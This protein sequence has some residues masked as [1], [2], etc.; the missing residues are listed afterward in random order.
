MQTLAYIPDMTLKMST[1]FCD[2]P[3]YYTPYMGSLREIREIIPAIKQHM[4]SLKVPIKLL[5]PVFSESVV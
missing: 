1:I 3:I 4:S 5:P 2:I